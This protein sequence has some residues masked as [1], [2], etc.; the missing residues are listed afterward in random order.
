LQV[1]E[2]QNFLLKSA[3]VGTTADHNLIKSLVKAEASGTTEKDQVYQ[4][5]T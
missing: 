2:F 3:V 4:T 5:G 1:G